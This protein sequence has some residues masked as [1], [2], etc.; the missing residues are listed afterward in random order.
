MSS[1]KTSSILTVSFT[2]SI[3]RTLFFGCCDSRAFLPS[4]DEV[5]S[6][7]RRTPAVG[8]GGFGSSGAAPGGTGDGVAAIVELANWEKP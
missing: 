7:G 4:G 1:T 3:P 6:G 2:K 8:S 5:T